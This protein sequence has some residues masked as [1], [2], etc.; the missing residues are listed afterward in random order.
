MRFS[1]SAYT[2]NDAARWG[3]VD[4]AMLYVSPRYIARFTERHREWGDTVSIAD[5]DLVRM[6]LSEDHNSAMSEITLS[7]F[8]DGGVTVRS[9]TVTQKW[10]SEHGKYKLVDEAVRRGDP[11]VFAPPAASGS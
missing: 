3:Q 9:S 2:L 6:Q 4:K 11:A 8:S 5:V 10:E 7:W 1:E